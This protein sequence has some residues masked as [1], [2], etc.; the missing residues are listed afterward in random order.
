MPSLSA[1]RPSP[2]GGAQ[3]RRTRDTPPPPWVFR[4]WNPNPAQG[5]GGAVAGNNAGG[6]M[7]P[8]GDGVAMAKRAGGAKPPLGIMIVNVQSAG[9]T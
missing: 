4:G 9:L 2:V 1:G 8:P 5:M 7:L 3:C 6:P